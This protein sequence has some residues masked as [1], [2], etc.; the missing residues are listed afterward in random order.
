LTAKELSVLK[1]LG[2][3]LSN[4]EISEASGIHLKTVKF[5]V[6]KILS[7]LKVKNRTEAALLVKQ[8]GLLVD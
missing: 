6:S 2:K 3:G 5:N 8:S 1:F 4:P 7:K